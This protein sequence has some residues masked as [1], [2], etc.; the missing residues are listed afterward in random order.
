MDHAPQPQL[1]R[2]P[3][4]L[5]A[6]SIA[7]FLDNQAHIIFYSSE[8]EARYVA[9]SRAGAGYH[10]PHLAGEAEHAWRIARAIEQLS[11][12]SPNGQATASAADLGAV[13]HHEGPVASSS[14]SSTAGMSSS[15][16]GQPH[17]L[18]PSLDQHSYG[19]APSAALYDP[20]YLASAVA[21]SRLD[22]A[23][24]MQHHLSHQFAT[25]SLHD[26]PAFSSPP[27]SSPSSLQQSGYAPGLLPPGAS[28][29]RPPDGLLHPSS[30]GSLAGG[31]YSAFL[32]DSPVQMQATIPGLSIAPPLPLGVAGPSSLGGASTLG[33]VQESPTYPTDAPYTWCAVPRSLPVPRRFRG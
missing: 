1:Q 15:A 11:A 8:I 25:A 19:S 27:S 28:T 10:E 30:V 13:G 16:F 26:G 21:S 9:M 31:S 32:Q 29:G 14:L 3:P 17:A 18:P 20:T 12:S 5:A 2:I 33:T 24:A 6:A 4:D 23:R 7:A 22:Y